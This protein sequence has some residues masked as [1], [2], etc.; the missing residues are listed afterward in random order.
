MQLERVLLVD[1][2]PDIRKIGALSL[3]AVG[4]L[5]VQVASS[6]AEALELARKAPPDCILLDVMM[7]GLDGPACLQQLRGQPETR[8]VPVLFMTAKV[9]PQEME[10]YLAL[11]AAGVIRKPFDPM[12]LARDVRAL[13]EAAQGRG[14]K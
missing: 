11:G 9:Q 10:R 7:P 12:T 4:G 5:E 2:E 13:L 14:A 8:E 3:S 1:D 6:G